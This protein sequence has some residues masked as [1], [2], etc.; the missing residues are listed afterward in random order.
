MS[1]IC[2]KKNYITEVVARID[3]AKSLQSLSTPV[4]PS[5]VQ[6]EIKKRYQ[7]YEPN[8]VMNSEFH[9][10]DKGVSSINN[11]FFQW[12]F[13]SEDRDKS[14][15]INRDFIVVRILKYSNYDEFKLDVNGPISTVVSIEKDVYAKRTGLRYVNIFQ[16]LINDYD[17]VEK[18]FNP[19]FAKP[20]SY[21]I[22]DDHCSRMLL[23]SEYTKDEIKTRV[24][25]GMHN[26]D[27]PAKLKR[28]DFML[29]IDSFVDTPHAI[30]DIN[31][32]ITELHQEIQSKFENSVTDVLRAK[33]DE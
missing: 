25:S 32:L 18:Y 1:E 15:T 14:F 22:D 31:Q 26:P 13:H 33:M 5:E 29:D 2:Y 24:Q 3:F 12:T 30:V 19:M 10:S 9:F 7:I 11:K 17:E 4:L 28:K 27:Y 23:V 20:F 16:N 6:K 8:E 21:L